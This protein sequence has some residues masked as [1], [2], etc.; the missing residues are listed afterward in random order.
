VVVLLLKNSIFLAKRGCFQLSDAFCIGCFSGSIPFFPAWPA[1][2]CGK[3]MH[4]YQ[5]SKTKHLEVF[6]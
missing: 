4:N 3:L 1:N 5:C 2:I 6:L